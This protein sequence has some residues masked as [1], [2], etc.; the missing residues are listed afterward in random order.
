MYVDMCNKCLIYN[1]VVQCEQFIYSKL[2]VNFDP[3]KIHEMKI[4]DGG[5]TILEFNIHI[6]PFSII[7]I[8]I[9]KSW[10]MRRMGRFFLKIKTL[11]SGSHEGLG[12]SS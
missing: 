2:G 11:I 10:T 12:G 3:F 8:G 1:T 7:R 6:R 9:Q 4:V 5:S